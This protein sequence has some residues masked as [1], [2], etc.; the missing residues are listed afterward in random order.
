MVPMEEKNEFEFL[1][2]CNQR[3]ANKTTDELSNYN[4]ILGHGNSIQDRTYIRVT[5]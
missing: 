3:E 4:F 5:T 1:Y 2:V